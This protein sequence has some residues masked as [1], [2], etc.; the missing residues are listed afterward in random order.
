VRVTEDGD[1]D[2]ATVLA[3]D[4]ESGDATELAAPSYPRPTIEDEDALA[5]AQFTDEGGPVR[6]YWVE[7]GLLRV[8]ALGGGTWEIDPA[9]G[10]MTALEEDDRPTLWGPDG[11]QRIG[12]TYENGTTS[13]ALLD[14]A[15]DEVVAT[16]I[17][18]RVSHVRWAPD[19]ERVVFTV[20]RL[21]S[22]GGVLQDL[23]LWDLNEAAPMQLTD[24]GAAFGAEWRGAQALWSD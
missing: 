10:T 9:D 2:V 12:T 23:F 21:A 18:G 20:G 24:T 3:V 16:S 19:G 15:G 11:E 6:L 1:N 13:I 4:F 5:E 7:G 17:E 8:W 22:G 14:E